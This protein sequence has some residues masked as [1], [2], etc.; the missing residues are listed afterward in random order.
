[1]TQEDELEDS[2]LDVLVARFLWVT[3]A[4]SLYVLSFGPA[5]AWG[6]RNAAVV[7]PVVVFYAPLWLASDFGDQQTPLGAYLKWCGYSDGTCG[8]MGEGG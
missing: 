6:A 8:G 7:I 1:M 4:V 2:P 3:V 5:V